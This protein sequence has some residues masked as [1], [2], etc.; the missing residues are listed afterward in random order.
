M[1]STTYYS[2]QSNHQDSG[3]GTQALDLSPLS[4]LN[5][6]DITIDKDLPLNNKNPTFTGLVSEC[7]ALA[8]RGF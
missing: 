3:L 1:F 6:V 5:P 2:G 8:E 4:L 7:M